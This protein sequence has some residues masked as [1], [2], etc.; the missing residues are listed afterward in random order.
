MT[1]GAKFSSSTSAALDH[2]EQQRA[3][4]LVF[5]VEGDRALVAR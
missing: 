2:A 5:Q 3:A 4:A 1:P